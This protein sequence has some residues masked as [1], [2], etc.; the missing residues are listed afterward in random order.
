MHLDKRYLYLLHDILNPFNN[1]VVA[2]T[3]SLTRTSSSTINLLYTA[4]SN[5]GSWPEIFHTDNGVEYVNKF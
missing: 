2:W 5:S 1:S 4:R 3:L